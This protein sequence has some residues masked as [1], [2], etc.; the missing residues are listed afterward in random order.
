MHRLTAEFLKFI[1]ETNS[2]L[3]LV[4]IGVPGSGKSTFIKN[5][6]EQSN[7]QFSIMSTDDFV[8]SKAKEQN[9]T[10]SDVWASTIDDATKNMNNNATSA[11]LNNKNVIWDQT[12][13]MA[14]KRK[15]ILSRFSNKYKKIAIVFRVA[16]E[17]LNKRLVNREKETGK[18]IPQPVIKDMLSKFQMPSTSEG[19]SDIVLFNDI[20]DKERLNNL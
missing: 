13:T 1:N 11:I 9:K 12:N 6:L 5:L 19:F 20:V 14:G 4:L 18:K 16:E 2:P 3:L 15:S 7:K 17:E 8:E 10:Y